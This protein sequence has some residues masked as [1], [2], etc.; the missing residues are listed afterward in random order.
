MKTIKNLILVIGL[1]FITF[2][3]YSQATDVADVRIANATTA[4]GRNLPVGTK[5]YDINTGNYWVATAG[6]SSASTLTTASGSFTQLN[7]GGTDSQDLSL[8]ATTA[9]TQDVDIS[10]GNSVTLTAATT[11]D[12][13]LLTAT[14]FDEITA[15]TAKVSNVTTNLSLGTV[16]GTTMDVNSSDGTNATL[17]AATGTDAGLL[18]AAD[19]T[20]LDAITSG[21][22]VNYVVLTESFEETSGVA[23]SHSLTQTAASGLSAT[24]SLN[25]AILDPAD[26]TLTTTTITIDIPVLQYDKVTITYSY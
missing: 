21:A 2:N 4:F 23:T 18:T 22:Q 12:A 15:N 24:V 26:Y 3:S 5:V 16:T 9:T 13:G 20:K 17:V 1:M 10:G 7:A 25:G 6:V 19:K 8:G 11:D 14:K